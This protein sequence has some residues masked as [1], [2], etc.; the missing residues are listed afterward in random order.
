MWYKREENVLKLFIY[1]QPGAKSTEIVGV[2][3]GALKIRLNT[4]PLDG[5]ANKA[6]Q[7]FLAQHFNVSTRSVVL[8][9]GERNRKKIFLISHSE[10][11]PES[12]S[13]IFCGG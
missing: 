11:D 7:K 12:L 8:V 10:V 1:V 4:P 2:H 6:L 5:R 13:S 3:D 9:S